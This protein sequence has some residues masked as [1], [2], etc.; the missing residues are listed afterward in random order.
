[1]RGSPLALAVG[2]AGLGAILG[3]A[4]PSAAQEPPIPTNYEVLT[5]GPVH[6]AFAGPVNYRPEPGLVAPKSPPEPIDEAP[7]DQRPAGGDIRWMPGY[8]QFDGEEKDYLWVSGFWRDVPPGRRWVPGAWQEAADGWHRAAG[9]WAAADAEAI[10]YIPHPPASVDAGPSTPPPQAT[11]VYVPGC[12]VWREVRFFWRPGFWCD[13]HPDWLWSPAHYCWTPGGCVFVEGFWDHPYHMRGLLFAPIRL[14][15]G[16]LAFT[17]VPR[18]VVQTDFLMTALFVGPARHQYCFGDYYGEAYDR[19]GFV[20]WINY[21]PSRRTI[22][23]GFGYYRTA[24]RQ[25]P[26]WEQNLT[27]LYAGRRSGEVARPPRTLVQQNTAVN[28]ITTNDTTNVIVTKNLNI[29]NVQNVSVVAPIGQMNNTRVTALAALAPPAGKGGSPAVPERVVK[30]QPGSK[31]EVARDTKGVAE[32]RLVA[33]N[34]RQAEAK[35]VADGG[36]TAK[37]ADGRPRAAVKLDLPPMNPSGVPPGTVRP[38]TKAPPT[39]PL[40]RHVERDPPEAKD[41]PRIIRPPGKRKAFDPP[42]T[43]E[44]DRPTPP[45]K[46]EPRPPPR[47]GPPDKDDPPPQKGPSTADLPPRKA[48]PE[49]SADLPAKEVPPK[50]AP[51]KK[52]DG[53]GKEGAQ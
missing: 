39:P 34:R 13:Y 52:A 12:W 31:E 23:P 20:A 18:Y 22:D 25:Q 14:A 40:P 27:A 19:L 4:P 48:P 11:D 47:K 37:T 29:T 3:P 28:N 32:T 10:E 43:K 51:P 53:K 17:Y 7:P 41:P 50:K 6:E 21:Q 45:R 5:R 15:P 16:G 49:Q 35:L 8:W 38:L 44:D 42:V 9:F 33:H 26:A 36:M 2:L 1:M 46:A 30:L 24:Y